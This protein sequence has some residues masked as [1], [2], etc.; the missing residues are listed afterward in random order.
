MEK[1]GVREREGERAARTRHH[2]DARAST[3]FNK[4][5]EGPDDAFVPPDWF[6]V[7]IRLIESRSQRAI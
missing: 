5:I 1:G 4:A 6:L 3:Y 2:L 7:A